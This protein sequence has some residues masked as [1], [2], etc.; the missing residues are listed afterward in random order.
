MQTKLLKRRR[1]Q[2]AD[3]V[4]NALDRV[5]VRLDKRFRRL[6]HALSQY[7]HLGQHFIM[8]LVR[9]TA[10]FGFPVSNRAPA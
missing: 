3:H 7:R 1:S 4:A 2:A 6:R 10:T 9:Q 5:L 8:Q